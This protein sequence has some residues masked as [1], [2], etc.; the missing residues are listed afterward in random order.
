VDVGMLVGVGSAQDM[1]MD[2]AC[3]I[4]E[5]RKQRVELRDRGNLG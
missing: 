3:C 2:S 1:H 5:S 4:P